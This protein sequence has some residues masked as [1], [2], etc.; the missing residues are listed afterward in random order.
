MEII[1]KENIEQ[2][3]IHE[4]STNEKLVI[5]KYLPP[6]V[7]NDDTNKDK[8]LSYSPNK[9]TIKIKN[10]NYNEKYLKIEAETKD[11]QKNILTKDTLI[12]DLQNCQEKYKSELSSLLKELNKILISG[13][14]NNFEGALINEEH[15]EQLEKILKKRQKDI[16]LSKSQNKIYKEQLE[17]YQ[18]KTR[19]NTNEKLEELQIKI[20]NVKHE[21]IEL[22]RKVIGLKSMQNIKSKEL[23]KYSSNKIFPK[24][25]N[26]YTEEMKTLSNKKHEYFIKLNNNKKFLGNVLMELNKLETNFKNFNNNNNQNNNKIAQEIEL[27]KKDLNGEIDDILNRVEQNGTL[28]VKMNEEKK[29]E[30]NLDKIR[31]TPKILK[32]MNLLVN[33]KGIP[34]NAKDINLQNIR[35]KARDNYKKNIRSSH[36]ANK[37]RIIAQDM[38]EDLD[39]NNINYD[40]CT[41]YQYNEMLSKKEHYFDINLKLEKSIKEIKKMYERK[42]R[43]INNQAEAN[44]KKLT[45]LE[46]ENELIKSEIADLS[47]ISKLVEEQS[48]LKN[49]NKKQIE[50]NNDCS[51]TRN[52]ILNDLKVL[53][54]ADNQKMKNPSENS[55]FYPQNNELNHYINSGE[56]TKNEMKSKFLY[57]F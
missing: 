10:K 22:K 42:I 19:D 12:T 28:I 41:D 57:Y 2:E 23:E 32:P 5:P 16:R 8:N 31:R 44:R 17:I 52:D 25:I 24:D 27:L 45:V 43:D 30:S 4:E 49:E 1:Q 35:E 14:N 40:N 20:D 15:V 36:S 33:K 29:N 7:V 37:V 9:R 48:K 6:L 39:L 18:Q 26:S 21:N 56:K 46:Q 38:K 54:D 34:F 51:D 13:Q 47:K 53:N 11:L 3:Q 55:I 50:K